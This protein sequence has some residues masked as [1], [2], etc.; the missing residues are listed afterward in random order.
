MADLDWERLNAIAHK[1]AREMALKWPV[2]EADDV[3][4]EIMMHIVEQAEHVAKRADDDE[5]IRQLS[6][7]VAKSYASREQNQRDLLDDQ[8]Y[9]TPEEARTALRSFL[10]TDE[11]ISSL[12]GKKDDLTRCRI[13]DNIFAARMDASAGLR[14]L[15]DRY[16]EVLTRIYIQGLPPRDDAER[17][18]SYRAAD[19]LAVAMNSHIRSK[20]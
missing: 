15:T 14:K 16:R 8:Y 11:E 1:V 3:R 10:H 12:I 7:R 6:W 17:R 5:F 4:Q 2:V 18:T 19:A 9:Y 20:K 13:S